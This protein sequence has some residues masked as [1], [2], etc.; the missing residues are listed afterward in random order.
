ML[1][2]KMTKGVIDASAINVVHSGFRGDNL[3]CT[4]NRIAAVPINHVILSTKREY[5]PIWR[6]GREFLSKANIYRF[7][8]STSHYYQ[9]YVHAVKIPSCKLGVTAG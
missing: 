1:F 4:R 3:I 9:R 2:D 7:V 8:A 6:P 5:R